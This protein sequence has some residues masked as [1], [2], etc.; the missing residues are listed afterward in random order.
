MRSAMAGT[1]AVL[2]TE[3]A[4]VDVTGQVRVSTVDQVRAALAR[5]A[6]R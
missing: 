4:F 3:L 1:P 5:A 6:S 2:G